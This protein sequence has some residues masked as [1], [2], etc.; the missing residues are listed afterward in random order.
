MAIQAKDLIHRVKHYQFAS[1]S[2]GS[3]GQTISFTRKRTTRTNIVQGGSREQVVGSSVQP[4]AS[5]RVTAR[6]LGTEPWGVK[7]RLVQ[8]PEGTIYEIV[9]LSDDGLRI[10][11]YADVT[12]SVGVSD[13][14]VA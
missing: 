12:E 5:G 10:W 9:G 7:D 4:I 14:E 6:F 3:G 1:T 13:P 2:D 11:R 8:H